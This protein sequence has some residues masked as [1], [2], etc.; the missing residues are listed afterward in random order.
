MRTFN[1]N[2]ICGRGAPKVFFGQNIP[3]CENS[4]FLRLPR[5]KVSVDVQYS[6]I[7]CIFSSFFHPTLEE[8][9]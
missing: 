5:V 3:G 7:F 6:F 1:F 9:I 8:N 2:V 4:L